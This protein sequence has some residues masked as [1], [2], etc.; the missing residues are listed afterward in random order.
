MILFTGFFLLADDCLAD[1]CPLLLDLLVPSRE[2]TDRL[3]TRRGVIGFGD[4]PSSWIAGSGCE[5]SMLYNGLGCFFFLSL[6]W[7]AL[8]TENRNR[9]VSLVLAWFCK[10]R[11]WGMQEFVLGNRYFEVS[12]KDLFFY[13]YILFIFLSKHEL[14]KMRLDDDIL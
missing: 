10:G 7:A 9:L 13:I 5:Y 1:D 11:G 4:T 6:A 2:I 8:R 12:N 14:A 3:F